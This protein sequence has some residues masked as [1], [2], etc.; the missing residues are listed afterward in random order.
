MGRQLMIDYPSFL[1]NVRSMD[2]ILRDLHEDA[3]FWSIEGL[4]KTSTGFLVV[5]DIEELEVLFSS[6]DTMKFSQAEYSQPLCT[7]L[8]IAIIDLLASWGV[9][10]SAVVGHSS[11]EVAAAYA[12]GALSKEGALITSFYR[13]FVCQNF[14]KSGGMVAVGLGKTEVLPFL[15]RDVGIACENSGSSVTLSGNSEP[16]EQVM[17]A[18]KSQHA[19]AF[20]RKLQVNMAYHSGKISLLP[21]PSILNRCIRPHEN[22]RK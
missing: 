6:D 8:Q 15:V 7:A 13:G 11:G 4:P 21:L 12:A 14:T 16:L 3:P 22:R 20:I 5:A 2:K 9:I 17:S 1:A 18:I 10:P 19:Q